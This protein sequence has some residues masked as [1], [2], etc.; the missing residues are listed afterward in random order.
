MNTIVST[1][2]RVA[3]LVP[4]AVAAAAAGVLLTPA[5]P[6]MAESAAVTIGSLEA[7]GFDVKVDRIGSAPLDQCEVTNVRN[8]REQRSLVR[9]G[10]RDD[11]NDLF[12][13]VV[14]RTITVSLDCSR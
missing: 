6:A 4:A 11:R 3:L 9:V 12:P 5:V 8:P 13:V 7:Q 14:K 10:D 1:V 2:T